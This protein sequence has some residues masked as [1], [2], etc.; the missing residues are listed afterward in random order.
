[1]SK[2]P[3]IIYLGLNVL[4]V[5]GSISMHGK[6]HGPWNAMDAL[7]DFIVIGALLYWGGF[8]DVLFK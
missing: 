2:W 7:F 8:F 3:A 5:V 4:N 6:P 1:M